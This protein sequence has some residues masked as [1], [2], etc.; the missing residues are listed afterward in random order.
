LGEVTVIA[1]FLKR[2][3]VLSTREEQVRFPRRRFG[4][5]DVIEYVAVLVGYA[6]SGERTLKAFDERVQLFANTFMAR[7]ARDRLPA[8]STLSR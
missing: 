7:I 2:Q 3:G 8:R 1:L 4:H 5:D 6:I